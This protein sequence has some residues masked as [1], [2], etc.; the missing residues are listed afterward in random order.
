MRHYGR[1]GR[2]W[3]VCLQVL[4]PPFHLEVGCHPSDSPDTIGGHLVSLVDGFLIDASFGQIGDANP[5]V[6]VPSVFVGELL[7]QGA[8]FRDAYQFHTPFGE[9]QYDSRPMSK[10]YRL[11]PDWGPSAERDAVRTAIITQIEGYCHLNGL[12]SPSDAT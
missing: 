5:A 9:L 11:S 6:E 3:E 12:E 4:R 1:H 8:P 7:P 10:D 2:A